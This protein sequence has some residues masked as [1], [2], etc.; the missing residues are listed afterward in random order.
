MRALRVVVKLWRRTEKPHGEGRMWAIVV[1]EGLG[2][3]RRHLREML[4]QF[5]A[6]LRRMRRGWSKRRQVHIHVQVKNALMA[7]DATHLGRLVVEQA[8]DLGAAACEVGSSGAS[9]V[10]EAI[11]EQAGPPLRE[12]AESGGIAAPPTPQRAA[13][14]IT[15]GCACCRR[16]RRRPAIQAEVVRDAATT[17]LITVVVGLAAGGQDIIAIMERLR[18]EGALPLVF[19]SDNGPAYQCAALA[20][21]FQAHQVIH[22]FSLP[23]TPQHNAGLERANRELKEDAD[24]AGDLTIEEVRTAIWQS[25]LRLN[26]RPRPSRGGLTADEL[27]SILPDATT[28]VSRE[29]FY[30]ATLKATA[31]AVAGLT[32]DRARRIATRQAAL[33][34]LELFN[35]ITVTRG[36]D[37]H[38]FPPEWHLCVRSTWQPGL[39]NR[40]APPSSGA[41]YWIPRD[42]LVHPTGFEID[43]EFKRLYGQ[44]ILV[45]PK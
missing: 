35:L 44:W 43:G 4:R 13:R 14:G 2:V 39:G 19:L 41:S 11:A 10:S 5:K 8:G 1:A 6:R 42:G 25:R 34:T 9:A 36:D 33:K 32:S 7:E 17:K 37:A 38:P 40:S 27:D 18:S 21:W 23:H 15:P 12:G 31:E 16:R 22:L 20:A 3:R 30:N 26:R 29:A 28:V 24:L 45:G